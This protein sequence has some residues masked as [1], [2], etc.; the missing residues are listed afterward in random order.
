MAKESHLKRIAS[1]VQGNPW[2][3]GNPTA[4]RELF[5]VVADKLAELVE[6]AR[7]EAYE[8]MEREAYAALE[9]EYQSSALASMQTE[10]RRA[11][12][13]EEMHRDVFGE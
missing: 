7:K 13:R 1:L 6:E 9:R 10:A 5:G 4:D 8:A 12:W 3:F 2:F 11:E